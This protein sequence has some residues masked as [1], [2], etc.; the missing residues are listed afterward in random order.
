MKQCY[1]IVNGPITIYV[2]PD[3]SGVN[4]HFKGFTLEQEPAIFYTNDRSLVIADVDDL[5]K[6]RKPVIISDF[7]AGFYQA[8]ADAEREKYVKQQLAKCKEIDDS[9]NFWEF[10]DIALKRAGRSIRPHNVGFGGLQN[11]ANGIAECMIGDFRGSY[12]FISQKHLGFYAQNDWKKEEEFKNKAM[13]LLYDG[14]YELHFLAEEQEKQG[15]APPAYSEIVRISKFLE[16]KRN[17][18]LILQDHFEYNLKAPRY[19]SDLMVSDLI[20]TTCNDGRVSLRVNPHCR[21][22]KP[23][24]SDNLT[25]DDFKCLVHGKRKLFFNISTLKQLC[26]TKKVS[27]A[28]RAPV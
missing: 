19:S 8:Q 3:Y 28:E 21:V 26:K 18:R 20:S 11:I 5:L 6:D 25:L 12:D 14:N 16:G 23:R 27:N 17:V 13:H 10:W 7:L 15:I 22:S 4:F 1:Q 2:I 9:E 24:I